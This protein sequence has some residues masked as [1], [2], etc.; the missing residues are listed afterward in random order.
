MAY[1]KHAWRKLIENYVFHVGWIFLL[2]RVI[3]ILGFELP[4]GLLTW[5]VFFV[6]PLLFTLLGECRPRRSIAGRLKDTD[7][8][9]RIWIGDIFDISDS[10]FVIGTNSTFDT[11][12]SIIDPGSV[13]GQFTRKYYGDESNLDRDLEKQLDDEACEMI[14]D[15]RKGKRRRYGMGTVVKVQPAGETAYMVAI[16]DMNEH[17]TASGSWEDIVESLGKLW[18]YIGKRGE[19]KPVAVPVLGTGNARI[20]QSRE[21]VIKE[22]ISSFIAACSEKRFSDRLTIVIAKDDY[23]KCKIDI[24]ELENYVKCVCRYTRF[25]DKKDSGAGREA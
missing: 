9:I 1:W 7:V 5:G 19:T 12:G 15:S 21:Q 14:Q 13:Q 17:G 3:S 25:K 11:S 24:A 8:Q 22:I 23:Y 6:A 16:A 18:Y 20:L 10:A 2:V 4:R